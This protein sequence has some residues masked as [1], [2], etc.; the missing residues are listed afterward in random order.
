MNPTATAELRAGRHT[1][2]LSRPDKVFFPDDA[3][4]KADLARYYRTAARHMLGFGEEGPPAP[5]H[6]P[7]PSPSSPPQQHGQP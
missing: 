3:I 6:R 1:V 5:P 2:Q 4:T 7:S